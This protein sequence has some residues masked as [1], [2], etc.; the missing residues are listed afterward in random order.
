MSELTDT[1]LPRTRAAYRDIDLYAPDRRPSPVD[2]SDNTNRWGV[3][4]AALRAVREAPE[5]VT[6]RYP[7]LY[8]SPLKHALAAYA[9]VEPE[10]IVTGCGSD[11]V[12]DSA[13]RAFAE[14]GTRIM[15]PEPSFP[16]IPIFARMNGLELGFTPLTVNFDVSVESITEG[17]PRVIYICSPNNPTG[18]VAPH[19]TVERVLAT[20]QAL[21]IVDE[22]Y[23]EYS[24]ESV[25]DLLPRYPRLLI[26]RTMSKA[27]GLAGM[28]VGYA[29]GTPRVVA[30]VEKSRGPYKIN[31]LAERAA[32]A[33][34]TQDREWVR[35]RIAMAVESRELLTRQLTSRGLQVAPSAANF[36]F[37]PI[38]NATA[39]ALTMRKAG[40]AVRAFEGL[41]AITPELA[42]ANGSA[43]R[44]T[45]GPRPDIETM[46]AA[47]DEAIRVCA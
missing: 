21:L 23:V 45:A 7:D 4:P 24:G 29:L 44:I 32:I 26:V 33:A 25:V 35:D 8:A 11:D 38:A 47:L 42:A 2:L 43:L 3:P 14:P 20:T 16:M 9:G 28:R 10:M 46:L 18:T 40:V 34:L 31:A 37:A 1:H 27:F 17:D 36:V 12:L 6:A 22:A 15:M 39:I 5:E 13:I 19:A 30:E 41:P